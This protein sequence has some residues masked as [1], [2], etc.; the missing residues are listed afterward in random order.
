MWS[1]DISKMFEPA[2]ES[3]IWTWKMDKWVWN[4]GSL[5]VDLT[6]Q[7]NKNYNFR[8]KKT[9]LNGI[10]F[11]LGTNKVGGLSFLPSYK[12]NYHTDRWRNI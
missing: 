3:L 12:K 6:T 11:N 1:L 2:P 8:T 10:D 7:W 9:E 4:Y 5:A